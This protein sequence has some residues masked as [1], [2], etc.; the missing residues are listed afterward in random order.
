MARLETQLRGALRKWSRPLSPG[1]VA[2]PDAETV[3]RLAALGY[4]AGSAEAARGIREELD[5][6]RGRTDPHDNQRLFN[7]WSAAVEDM[8]TGL[9]LEAIRKI[10]T[11]L[12][13]DPTNTAALTTLATLYLEQAKRPE[14]AVELYEKSLALDPYQEEAHYSMA[15]IERVKGNLP[16]ALE[17]CRAILR[18]EPRSVRGL[19]EMGMILQAMGREAEARGAFEQSL[20]ADPDQALTLLALGALHGR[21]G[22]LE[23]AGKYLK[24]AQA[25]EPNHPAVL[26]DVAIWYLK[27]GNVKEAQSHLQRVLA[28]KPSDPDALY[29]LGK[30]F[31]EQGDIARAEPLL[32]RARKLASTDDR[33]RRIDAMLPS[34]TP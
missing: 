10:E 25:L 12:S 19:S 14:K 34:V 11:V 18:F 1:S 22:R 8:R 4:V 6:V 20:L 5:D 26:Y 7:V 16:V 30:L 13:G 3:Q 9:H 21:A 23:E 15:R 27:E 2:G 24:R 29:V 33:R 32:E 17:H 31:Y 28:L